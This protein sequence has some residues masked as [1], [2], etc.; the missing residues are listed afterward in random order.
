M[1]ASKKVV[2]NYA[3]ALFELCNKDLQTK[4][5]MLHALKEITNVMTELKEITTIFNTPGVSKKEKKELV[6][7][8]FSKFSLDASVSTIFSKFLS[9][10]IDKGRFNLLP[11]IQ[12]EFSKLIDKEKGTV[13]VEISSPYELKDDTIENLRISLEKVLLSPSEKLKVNKKIEPELIGGIKV[14]IKDLVYDGSI[15]GRLENLK[16]RLG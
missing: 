15:K 7:K 6:G 11:E 5:D 9:L 13:H 14:K 8:I 4:E 3:L 16:R 1:R 10:L 12:D 2:K